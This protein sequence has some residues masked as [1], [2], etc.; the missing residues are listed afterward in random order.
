[1]PNG[2]DK[3]AN[4]RFAKSSEF[5]PVINERQVGIGIH[6]KAGMHVRNKFEIQSIRVWP[7]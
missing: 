4:S 5:C 6:P 1:M 2:R 7:R 3:F